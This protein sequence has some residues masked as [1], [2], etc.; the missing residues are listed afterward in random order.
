[1]VVRIKT[2]NTYNSHTEPLFKKLK[3]LKV[4]DILMLQKL[5]CYFQYFHKQ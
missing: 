4:E 3:L 5:K 1:M 2:L